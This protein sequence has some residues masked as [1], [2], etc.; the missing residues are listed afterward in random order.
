MNGALS[1]L[2]SIAGGCAVVEPWAAVITGFMSGNIYLLVSKLLIRLA[3][4][5]VVDAVPVHMAN[6]IWGTIA[7][8]FF[9][10][11]AKLE[12][13][14][15]SECDPGVLMG[16]NG[17]LLGCQLVGVLFVLAWTFFLMVPFFCMLNYLGL[18]R[19][20]TSDEVEGLDYSYHYSAAKKINSQVI[21]IARYSHDNR[22]NHGDNFR[23]NP[24]VPQDPNQ[25]RPHREVDT[26]SDMN[27]GVGMSAA[28][29]YD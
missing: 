9:A 2:V 15:G 11:S 8:G 23:D 1:G 19:A 10:T 16:G 20:S 25:N 26:L 18:F 28:G 4:D 24:I 22:L 17:T 3:I 12:L 6:G 13:A 21:P 7:V 5:D 14:Y 27:R 29:A